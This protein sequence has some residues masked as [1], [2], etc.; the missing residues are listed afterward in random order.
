MNT[1]PVDV[2]TKLAVVYYN[3]RKPNLFSVYVDVRLSSL[4]DQLDQIKDCLYHKDTWKVDSVEN[5]RP[6]T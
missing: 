6:S 4:K 3:G 1:Y 2:N 5:H